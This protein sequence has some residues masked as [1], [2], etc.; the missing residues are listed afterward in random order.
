MIEY[1]S[2]ALASLG[3]ATK[4]ISS[5]LDL[6][7]F[8]NYAAQLTE[9][10]SHI[11]QANS[12]IISEQ[13]LDFLLTAKIQELENECMRLKD[14]SA[15]KEHYALVQIADGVFAY[16]PNDGMGNLQAA[17]KLC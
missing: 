6:R 9:L 13:Q 11:I 16:V 7:E 10:Q 1:V 3:S 2:K 8:R 17:H 4:I 12:H 15:E 5:L 14:W